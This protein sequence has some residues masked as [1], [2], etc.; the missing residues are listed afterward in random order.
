MVSP[1]HVI[2]Q[3][4]FFWVWVEVDL[5]AHAAYAVRVHMM[6]DQCQGHNKRDETLPVIFHNPQDIPVLNRREVVS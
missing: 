4:Q 3:H 6:P 5:V 1:S 2:A